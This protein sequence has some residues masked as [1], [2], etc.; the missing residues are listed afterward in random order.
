MT[1]SPQGCGHRDAFQCFSC[2]MTTQ[3]TQTVAWGLSQTGPVLTLTTPNGET[4]TW[5]Q[6]YS[7][8]PVWAG[9]LITYWGAHSLL[10]KNHGVPTLRAP[11]ARRLALNACILAGM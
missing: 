1:T 5:I 11:L 9:G 6:R 3:E 10:K 7:T 2:A 8:W 4:T